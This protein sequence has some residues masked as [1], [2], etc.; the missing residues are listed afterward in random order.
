MAGFAVIIR[1]MVDNMKLHIIGH[2]KIVYCGVTK[3]W[4]FDE[5]KEVDASG[6]VSLGVFRVRIDQLEGFLKRAG[7]TNLRIEKI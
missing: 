3:E 1:R 2:R 5:T 6:L 7:V 4:D